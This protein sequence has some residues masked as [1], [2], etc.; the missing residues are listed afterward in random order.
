MPIATSAGSRARSSPRRPTSTAAKTGGSERGDELPEQLASV[1]KKAA[2]L[3]TKGATRARI[4]GRITCLRVGGRCIAHNKSAYKRYA[5]ACVSGRLRRLDDRAV[6]QRDSGRAARYRGVGRRQCHRRRAGDRGRGRHGSGRVRDGAGGRPR[7]RTGLARCGL[8]PGGSI[9]ISWRGFAPGRS[10]TLE[11][12]SNPISLGS[13]NASGDGSFTADVT[14]PADAPDGSHHVIASGTDAAGQPA[15]MSV[16]LVIDV[17]PP[18]ILAVDVTPGTPHPGDSVVISAHVTD[19]TAVRNVGLNVD[20]LHERD[21]L[22]VVAVRPL[23]SS[24]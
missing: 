8:V 1:T 24:A 15:T 20:V 9:R 17:I 22:V 16:P 10:V 4:G 3:C 6:A 21:P 7:S 11:L 2:P 18:E 12:H 19:A 13:V 23:I 14:I 5:F